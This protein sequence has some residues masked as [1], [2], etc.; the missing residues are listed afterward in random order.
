VREMAHRV[1]TEVAHMSKPRL[2]AGATD[3]EQDE[4][5]ALVLEKAL[6]AAQES[7][8]HGPE[9]LPVLREH[10]VVDAG[11][12]GV[13]L[14]VAGVLAGLRGEHEELPEVAHHEA[15]LAPHGA[16]YE[17]SE[18]RY[19]TNFVVSGRDLAG[20]RTFIPALEELGDSVLVVG[21][22]ANLRV[23]VH[24][25]D[26]DRAVALFDGLGTVARLDVADMHE[27]QQQ[28]TA[29]LGADGNGGAP[30]VDATC[31][32]VAVAAGEGMKRLYRDLGAYVV[33]G[34]SSLNPS[35][36]ELL[37]GIHGVPGEEVIVLPNS[38]NVI[39]AAERAAE[40]SEKTVAVVDSRWPQA[41]LSCLVVHDGALSAEENATRLA[42]A[43]EEIG[44]GAVAPAARDDRQERFRAGD[45]VGFIDD[46]IVAWGD[47]E[48]TF[49]AVVERLAQDS[50]VVTCVA[51]AGAPLYTQTIFNVGERVA[52]QI[53][54]ECF[55]GGQAHYWWLLAAE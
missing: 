13:T 15:T 32:V 46:Q 8:E 9:L 52:P 45:A 54:L 23:H 27:Q 3:E 12:Y 47:P 16:Q 40:L 20:G 36:F 39:M 44:V 21:D 1:A 6:T 17:E 42:A 10:G 43:L 22:A 19:C 7:V 31:G 51:G 34:G 48:E 55:D 53:E 29:R 4:V 38:S 2:D 11:G 28:R 35:T 5:L 50:E 26:P 14:L 33:E 24:T 18:F 49:A 25:D 41:G 30:V 37:A